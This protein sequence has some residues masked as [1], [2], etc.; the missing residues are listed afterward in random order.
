MEDNGKGYFCYQE[1]V[2]P[3]IG[4][5]GKLRFLPNRERRTRQ[6]PNPQYSRSRLR[7]S[8]RVINRM[9]TLN[10]QKI[11]EVQQFDDKLIVVNALI[12]A[13]IGKTLTTNYQDPDLGQPGLVLSF[14]RFC[15]FAMALTAADYD[16]IILAWKAK[17][18][19]DLIRP[20]TVIK[21]EFGPNR[22]I[23]TW[24]PGGVQTF[25]ASDFEALVRVMPHSE[26]VS[27]SA[28]LFTA[29][30]DFILGY[31][32]AIGVSDPSDFPIVFPTVMAG[33]SKVDPGLVPASDITL[34]YPGIEQMARVGSD[35]RLDGGMHFEASVTGAEAL[36]AGVAD[37]AVVGALGLYA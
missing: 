8:R 24:A 7:E 6:P 34:Q 35:S 26:Y 30:K 22:M 25:P 12:G 32:A 19:F 16:A 29:Q 10:D 4:T 37:F 28:C 11:I 23:T 27:G 31:L 18:E 17:V 2:T 13:F 3:H 20:T 5:E 15:H 21:E 1:H 9:A 33:E 14:E 36:C